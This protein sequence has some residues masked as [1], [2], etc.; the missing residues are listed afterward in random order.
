MADGVDAPRDVVREELA[1]QSAPEQASQRTGP[2]TQ[3]AANREGDGHRQHDPE[4]MRIADED[5]QTIAQQVPAVT[6]G[7]GIGLRE[8][9]AEMRMEEPVERAMWIAW[10]VGQRMVLG[11]RRR[12]LD[13]IAFEGHRAKDQ[14]DELD[15]RMGHEATVREH[16]V[17]AHSD[18]DRDQKVHGPK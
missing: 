8:D 2:A 4:Q 6:S 18:A 16:A 15:G 17:V 13:G 9:P 3:R 5:H 11:M 1:Y 12:P 10:P 7:I 14:E